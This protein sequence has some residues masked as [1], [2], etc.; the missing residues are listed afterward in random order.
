MPDGLLTHESLGQWQRPEPGEIEPSAGSLFVLRD[1][2][3]SILLR[4]AQ[5]SVFG[6]EIAELRW[7][8]GSQE[9]A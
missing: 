1:F 3:A 5:F 7:H 2:Q 6:Q 4:D 8:D 9:I